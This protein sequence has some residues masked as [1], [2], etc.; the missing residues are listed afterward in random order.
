MGWVVPERV[1]REEGSK[2][3]EGEASENVCERK[4]LNNFINLHL[5]PQESRGIPVPN[6]KLRH[7]AATRAE[8]D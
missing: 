3:G 6:L 2:G 8:A 5:K 7:T 1:N 4:A